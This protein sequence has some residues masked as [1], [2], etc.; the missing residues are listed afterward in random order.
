ME[1][2]LGDGAIAKET[3]GDPVDT[4]HLVC[5]GHADCQRQV[6]GNNGIAT[7]EACLFVE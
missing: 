6:A 4:R 2:T 3:T 7:V 5:Q 1:L